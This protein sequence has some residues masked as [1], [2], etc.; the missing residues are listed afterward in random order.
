MVWGLSDE[1]E[2][3]EEENLE[4]VLKITNLINGKIYI[5]ISERLRSRMSSH[6]S[7]RNYREQVI[8]KAIRKYGWKNFIM[9]IIENFQQVVLNLILLIYLICRTY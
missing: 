5:G 9:E 6:K 3:E 7:G 4:S 1:E 2:D 8:S